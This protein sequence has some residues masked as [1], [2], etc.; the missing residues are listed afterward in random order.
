MSPRKKAAPETP[1]RRI[2]AP[3]TAA[4]VTRP[5]RDVDRVV[6]VSRRADGEPD[7]SEGYQ[8]IGEAEKRG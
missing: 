4:T 8:V 3:E 2:E 1:E 6:M 5:A 7:Q